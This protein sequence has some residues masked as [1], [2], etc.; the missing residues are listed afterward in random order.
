M[1]AVVFGR[2]AR[3]GPPH[4]GELSK[5]PAMLGPGVRRRDRMENIHGHNRNGGCGVWP[6]LAIER[7]GD[8]PG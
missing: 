5:Q 6:S 3:R 7:I 8:Q 1:L 4:G 2:A